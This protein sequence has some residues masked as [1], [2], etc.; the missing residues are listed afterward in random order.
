MVAKARATTSD[1]DL[2]A[3]AA[4]LHRADPQLIRRIRDR[5][6]R[7]A[8]ERPSAGGSARRTFRTASGHPV[9][10]HRQQRL[11]ELIRL[12]LAHVD[13]D[14]TIVAVGRWLSPAAPR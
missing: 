10:W 14:L 9:G 11:A 1:R 6:Y 4:A 2:A 7:L 8:I 3:Y 12:G 5:Q 13:D